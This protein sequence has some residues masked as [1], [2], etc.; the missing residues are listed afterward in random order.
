MQAMFEVSESS[1]NET[2][3]QRTR[4]L[5]GLAV[6][7]FIVL[8]VGCTHTADPQPA[9]PLVRVEVTPVT[10]QNVP[11]YSERVG[12]FEGYLNAQIQPEVSGLPD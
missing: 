9:S 6:I 5:A 2:S 8:C 7:I 4:T 10:Q 3:T 11:I 12:T 1:L